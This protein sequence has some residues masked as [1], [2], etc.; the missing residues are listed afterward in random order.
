[1]PRLTNSI[2]R[3]ALAAEIED[4]SHVLEQRQLEFESVLIRRGDICNDGLYFLVDGRF[5]IFV[6]MSDQKVLKEHI[7]DH[8]KLALP[9]SM[10]G[11]V[12]FFLETARTATVINATNNRV[13]LLPKRDEVFNFLRGACPK[14]LA[15]MH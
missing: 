13:C 11:E 10:V 2:P 5:D 3:S 12:A 6:P 1:M 8:Q 15:C 14:L 4:L 7:K 9:G